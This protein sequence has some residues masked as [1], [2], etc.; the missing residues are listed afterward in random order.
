MDQLRFIDRPEENR[1]VALSGDTEVGWLIYDQ[2][3]DQVV[4]P[5]TVTDPAYRGQGIASQLV[6]HAVDA[7][8]ARRRAG[9]Q[10]TVVP[11]CPFVAQ[12]FTDHPDQADL[13]SA[14]ETTPRDQT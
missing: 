12:W 2:A 5:S 9:E 4:L 8:R 11:E 6:G 1:W 3:G 13:L 7:I 14:E 10:L